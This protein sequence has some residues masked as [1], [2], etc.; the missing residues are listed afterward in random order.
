M[1]RVV[2]LDIYWVSWPMDVFSTSLPLSLLPLCYLCKNRFSDHYICI[3]FL[4]QLLFSAFPAFY[5]LPMHVSSRRACYATHCLRFPYLDVSPKVPA[6]S[7]P[8]KV[9]TGDFQQRYR[10][11]FPIEVACKRCQKFS[12][13]L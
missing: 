1:I 6:P 10:F 5:A 3:K 13:F 11:H 8:L 2:S 7:L 9:S 12:L 4:C